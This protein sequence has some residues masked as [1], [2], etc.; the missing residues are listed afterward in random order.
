MGNVLVIGDL[1]LDEYIVGENYNISDEAPV[2]ILKVDEFIPKLGGAANV[3]NNIKALGGEA[4]LFGAIGEVS[5]GLSAS[6]FIK[7]MEENDLST[8]YVVQGEMKTTTKSRVIIKNQQLVRFDYE[9]N[10]LPDKIMKEIIRKLK[11]FDFNKIDIIVVSDYEKGVITKEVMDILKSSGV[12]IIIDP[13]PVDD[14]LY[15]GVFCMTPNLKEFNLFTGGNFKKNDLSG[16]DVAIDYYRKKMNLNSI[17]ITLGEKGAMCCDS[18]RCEIIFNHKIEVANTIGAGDTFLSA[19][20]LKIIQGLDLF[21]AVRFANIAASIVVSKKHTGVC[22]I[23]E[24][25]SMELL[26]E[27]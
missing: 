14:S 1:I 23:E 20:C 18:N 4:V 6:R 11:Y 27:K 15:E 22:L 13:K 24:I 25:N 3:A 9:Q 12:K 21:K 10:L 16:L 19:L 26:H 8:C 2:P 17:I 5:N 7:S